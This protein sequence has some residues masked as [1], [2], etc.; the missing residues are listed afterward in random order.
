M[1]GTDKCSQHSSIVWPVWLKIWVLVY[2]QSGCGFESHCSHLNFRYDASFQ[3]GVPFLEIH[4]S[5]ERGLT[6]K[7]V[8]EMI[9]K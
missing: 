3:Y 7:R 9:R 1:H 5:V 2:E 6:L 4:A 8:R